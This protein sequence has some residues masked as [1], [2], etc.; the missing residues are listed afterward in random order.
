MSIGLVVG[1]TPA[2]AG[3]A[4]NPPLD[5]PDAP[6]GLTVDDSVTRLA[7]S[8]NPRFSWQ[9]VDSSANQV[10]TGYEILVSTTPTI[11]PTDASV[12]WATG[13]VAGAEQSYVPYGGP[14][15]T[16]DTR[17]YW[18]VRT[19]DRK[20]TV[21]AF[22]RP[23]RFDTGLADADWQASWIRRDF[24]GVQDPVSP[25]EYSYVRK[26]VTLNASPITRAVAYASA[27]H[28]YQLWINGTRVDYGP[29]F[30]YP[31]AQYYQATDVTKA[32]RAGKPN[33]IGLLYHW[34]GSGQGRPAAEPGVIAQLSIDHADGTHETVVT[35]G[36]WRTRAAEWLQAPLR[37]DE[38]DHIEAIDGRATPLGWNEPGYDDSSWAPVHELG[39]H[40]VAPWTHLVAQEPRV[41]EHPI[42]PVS[43]KRLKSGAYVADFGKVYAAVPTA[44][45]AKGKALRQFQLR[46]GYLLEPD[47]QVSTRKGNQDTNLSYFY[48]ERDGSQTFRPYLYMGFR[49]LQ[50][51]NPHEALKP[52]DIVAY[53]RH[54]KVPDVHAGTFTS[55]NPTLNTIYELARHSALYGSQEQFVDTPTREKG[56]F[57][58]DAYYEAYSDQRAFGERA[59]SR[60]ALLEFAS[61]QARYWPDGRVNA[62]EPTGEGARDIPDGTEVFPAWAWEMYQETGNRELLRS[63]YLVIMNIATYLTSYIDPATGLITR[64]AGG[65][66]DY[67]GGI[68]DYPANMRYG[69]DMATA[70]KTTVNLLAVD[71]LRTAAAAASALGRPFGETLIQTAR[72]DA[73]TTAINTH[74]RRKDGIYIDGLKSS[75]AQSKHASEHANA[76]AL[77][78][79]VVPEADRAKVGRYIAKLGMQMGPGTVLELLRAL[80]AVDRDADLVRILSSAKQPG[81][82]Q[83]LAKG[84]TFT[85]ETWQPID[86]LG[87]SMSHARGAVVLVAL[88][89]ELLGVRVHAPGWASIDVTPPAK[90]LGHASGTVPTP[91]G[92]VH[93]AWE[94]NGRSFT[95]RLSVPANMTAF[96]H[97]PGGQSQ[98]VG[99]GA[100]VVRSH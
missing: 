94:R 65:G 2:I 19:A 53:A 96:V 6:R 30:S 60:Q 76:Y 83:E 99:S 28:Q 24:I 22:A 73:L 43:L 95:V 27:S 70:A 47:G 33:A 56:Q 46:V 82:A 59:L 13:K 100:H 93:I 11:A 58:G 89:Q 8:T 63:A 20:G 71:A 72:A 25:E 74:L 9:V 91:R 55:S 49:Y 61:S 97:L 54:T 78:F 39:R 66:T 44:T 84:G 18:T 88:Q 41:V 5:A 7:V 16:A 67:A 17:Y 12:L 1:A 57:L 80:G 3:V 75:G 23:E 52:A 32:L 26:D 14:A 42:H 29:S 86:V 40:P 68:V 21:G 38:G 87:D 36:S 31:D 35:D 45:F 10:Q 64:L 90:G 15:L 62:A 50:I 81:Y 4:V 34:Y 77:S 79:G 98:T 37:N 51:D 69:Y 92:P 85:W 48:T